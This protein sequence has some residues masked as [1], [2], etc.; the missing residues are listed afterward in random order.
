MSMH[1]Q[2]I[3]KSDAILDIRGK[4]NKLSDCRFNI[5]ITGETG[6][7][8]NIVARCI[9]SQ[10]KHL[11]GQMVTVNCA[12]LPEH[13]IESEIFGHEEGAFTGAVSKRKGKL[14]LADDGI[15]FLD[16]IGDLPLALQSK[17]LHVIQ[18]GTYSPLGSDQDY[19]SNAWIIAATNANLR[20]QIKKGLFRKDLYFRLNTINIE[21][22]PLRERKEDIPLLINHLIKKFQ[23]EYPELAE[24]KPGPDVLSKLMAYHWPGN[25]RQVQNCIKKLIVFESWD[26]ILSD[27]YQ[28]D[29]PHCK[30]E[31][32]FR[33]N[34]KSSYPGII[35]GNYNSADA[36][37][38]NLI[39]FSEQSDD[40]LSDISLKNL[41]KSVLDKV[42]EECIILALEKN[43][44]RKNKTAET[45]KIN[46][47]TLLNKI[48]EFEIQP[49][50]WV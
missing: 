12:A 2:L 36:W 33:S 32:K 49:P 40:S 11:T 19:K 18:C 4:I 25:V 17:L 20:Q 9:Y 30:P 16:E 3:G 13:L 29:V 26:N 34:E 48:K 50:D 14:N 39:D 38:S 31:Q 44:W 46:P 8:K 42:E 10:S 45:L 23:K 1:G 43:A 28:Q 6:V 47:R 27:L 24:K 7:G 22:P 5:L 41:T 37:V 21:I 35:P 15:L